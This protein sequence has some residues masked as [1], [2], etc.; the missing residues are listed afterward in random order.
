MKLRKPGT[1]ASSVYDVT[2]NFEELEEVT[3]DDN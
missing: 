3:K 2:K 1:L